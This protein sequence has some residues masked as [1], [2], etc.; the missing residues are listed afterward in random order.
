MFLKTI[1]ESEATGAIAEIYAKR[2]R[3]WASSW[4]Q[5]NV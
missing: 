1:A 5:R 4:K 2:R 3:R